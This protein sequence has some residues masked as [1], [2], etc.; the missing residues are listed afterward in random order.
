MARFADDRAA[1]PERLC[2]FVA[3]EWP[4]PDP[5]SGWGRAAAQWLEDHPG[6][7]LPWAADP[8]EVLQQVVRVRLEAGPGSRAQGPPYRSPWQKEAGAGDGPWHD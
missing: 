8:V 3:A 6:R 2:R 7:E 4:G 5:V 1:I